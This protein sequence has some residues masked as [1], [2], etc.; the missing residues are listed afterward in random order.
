M[1]RRE[2]SFKRLRVAFTAPEKSTCGA[3]TVAAEPVNDSVIRLF[4]VAWDL[5]ILLFSRT[6]TARVAAGVAEVVHGAMDGSAL[7]G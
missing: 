2:I 4:T 6:G 1:V 5:N 3:L 7:V